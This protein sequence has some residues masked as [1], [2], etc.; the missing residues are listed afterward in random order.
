MRV[1]EKAHDWY[2]WACWDEKKSKHTK[3]EGNGF[4][5]KVSLF[6]C[7][8]C[9]IE[10]M[11]MISVRIRNKYNWMLFLISGHHG[12]LCHLFFLLICV[13]LQSKPFSLFFIYRRNLIAKMTISCKKR[14]DVAKRIINKKLCTIKWRIYK[15]WNG[16]TIGESSSMRPIKQS[17]CRKPKFYSLICN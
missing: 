9:L 5:F 3:F 2:S 16:I 4:A 14:H 8:V 11:D 15:H 17:W 1:L 12:Y 7:S 10:I 13:F 6:L